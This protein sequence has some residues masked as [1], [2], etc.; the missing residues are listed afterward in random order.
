MNKDVCHCT[1]KVKIYKMLTLLEIQGD[2]SP[3]PTAFN[4]CLLDVLYTYL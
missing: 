2:D 3:K 1:K 4:E